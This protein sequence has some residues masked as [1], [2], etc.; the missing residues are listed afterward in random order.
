MDA[1]IIRRSALGD[2]LCAEPLIRALCHV[3][4]KKIAIDAGLYQELFYNHPNLVPISEIGSDAKIFD[5]TGVY[6]KQ[7]EIPVI[8][9]Y[10]SEFGISLEGLDL[11]PRLFI[12]EKPELPE[13]KWA[14]LDMGYPGGA[15]NRGFWPFSDWVAVLNVLKSN[16]FKIVYI[17]GGPYNGALTLDIA[18]D[19]SIIDLDLRGKTTIRQLISVISCCSLHVGIDSGPMHIV[20]SL[21]VPSVSIFTPLHPASTILNK[22]SSV[23]SVEAQQGD[24]FPTEKMIEEVLKL[25]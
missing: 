13:D 3:G 14:V 7:L 22:N 25:I 19:K 24:P 4:Y 11:D 18:I 2:V 12:N 1:L 10:I 20:Q 17:G 6:E 15:L 16:G 5:L 9:A 8:Q 21:N 23:V